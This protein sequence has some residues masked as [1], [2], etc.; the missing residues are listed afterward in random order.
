MKKVPLFFVLFLSFFN[1]YAQ[2]D[3]LVT[4]HTEKY[5]IKFFENKNQWNNVVKYKADLPAGYLL[6]RQNSLQYSFYDA[7]KLASLQP[8]HGAS[9]TEQYEK[10]NLKN[11]IIKAHSYLVEFVGANSNPKIIPSE[12]I[13]GKHHYYLGNDRS[14]WATRCGIYP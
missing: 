9:T 2:H 11:D 5:P 10:T 7:K 14:K 8:V 4:R 1:I 13:A 3:H 12:V 6:L